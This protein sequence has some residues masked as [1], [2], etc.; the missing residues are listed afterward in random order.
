M[1]VVVSPNMNLPVPV[2]SQEP[3]PQYA[4]DVDN[5]LGLI[6]QHNH[7]FGNG[8]QISPNG[9]NINTDLTIQD[10]N[11]TSVRTVRFFPQGGPIIASSPDLG[12]I[13]E[14]GVDLY[15][16]DGNGNQI[17]LTQ[18]GS[19]VGTSGSITGLTAP[20]S[21]TYSSG[22][23]T[24]TWQSNVN[25]PATMDM[26]NIIIRNDTANSPGVT[27]AVN[28]SIASDYQLTLPAALPGAT[29]FVTSDSSGNIGYLAETGAITIPLM[30]APNL[31]A[32]SSVTFFTSSNSPVAVTGLTT[33][34]T[35]HGKPVQ[36][37]FQSD[38]LGSPAFVTLVTGANAFYIY[39]DGTQISNT[40]YSV[41]AAV[42]G[43]TVSPTGLNFL[44]PSPSA[45]SHTYQLYIAQGSAGSVGVTNIIMIA[46]EL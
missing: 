31:V 5:C 20:A 32:S 8:V 4:S 46:R 9:L 41:A 34:L 16:N 35:T 38:G 39:R 42:T 12:V 19:I 23:S 36:L 17:R 3:G 26:G 1:S 11:L 45:A 29:S 10:N 22:S 33:T 44:D 21:A 25:T 2:V 13:Y 15:Y 18:A 30:A 6:D 37:T 40:V 14:A 27:I 24:F 28:A 43:D 7:A